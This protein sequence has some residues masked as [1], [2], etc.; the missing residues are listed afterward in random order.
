MLLVLALLFEDMNGN[1]MKLF[2]R[3][4]G[5]KFVLSLFIIKCNSLY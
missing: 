4:E 2:E 1:V 3:L 5:I